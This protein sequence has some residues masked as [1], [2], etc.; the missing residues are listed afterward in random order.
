MVVGLHVQRGEAGT[1]L[2][3]TPPTEAAP[4]A[5]WMGTAQH[6]PLLLGAAILVSRSGLRLEE[7]ESLRERRFRE[8]PLARR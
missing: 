5:T 2:E 7:R 6:L 1:T 4:H 8:A 3:V